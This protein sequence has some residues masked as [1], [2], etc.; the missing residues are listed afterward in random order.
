[1]VPQRPSQPTARTFWRKVAAPQPRGF[2][3][4]IQAHLRREGFRLYAP[5]SFVCLRSPARRY[6]QLV[7][8]R[9]KSSLA[10]SVKGVLS[11]LL[12]T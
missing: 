3:N 9:E 4:I 10:L 6:A 5:K 8:V 1:M 2:Y 11:T 7:A 12:R